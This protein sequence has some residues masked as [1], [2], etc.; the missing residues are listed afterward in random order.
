ML[1]LHSLLGD[2][3]VLQRDR[4]IVISGGASP[5]T[6]VTARF[7]DECLTATA[8][9]QGNWF[10]VF[11]AR[12]A[13]GPYAFSA[14]GEGQKLMREDWMIGEAWL[15]SGQSNMEWTL[16]MTPGSEADSAAADAPLV[17]CFTVPRMPTDEPAWNV[18]GKWEVA[19]PKTAGN[20][21][22]VAWF[23][24]RSLS[25]QLGCAVGIIV[26]AFGGTRIAS[27]LPRATLLA[28]RE[29]A[30]LISA[31]E[32]FETEGLQPHI[33][34]G[35]SAEAVGWEFGEL[36]D[37][38]WERL[39]V[40]GFWQDQGWA[41]NGAVWYRREVEIP[42][43]WRNQDLVL[44]FGACDDFDE[45]F[46]NGVRVGGM[47]PGLSGAYATPRDYP[48]AAALTAGCRLVIAVRIFDEWGFGGIVRAATLRLANA[49]DNPLPL[50]GEWKARVETAY[51][52]RASTRP[53]P[54]AV[55]YN[56]MIHPLRQ[57]AVRG[58]LWYQGE[59]DVERSGLYRMLLGDLIAAW[60]ADWN[61]PQKPF[62]IVQ[63]ANYKVPEAEPGESDWAEL[64]DAQLHTARTI[65]HTGLVVI[66][67]TGEADNVHPR[68]KR[69]VGERLARWALN[70]VY[71]QKVEPPGSPYPVGHE[72]RE[73]AVF[74]RFLQVGEG[75]RSRDGQPLRAFQISDPARRWTWAM[76]D[77]VAP[78]TIR[79]RSPAVAEP[80]AV[81]HGWQDNP[82]CNLENSAGLPATPFRTDEGKQ[83]SV[84]SGRP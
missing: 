79:I 84:L 5:G 71:G 36:D 59:S 80:M 35:R 10:A 62:G 45:T 55:L 11:S 25:E 41:L 58:F 66:I 76:A 23:F 67:D 83:H 39:Q 14:E 73:G 52:L 22:A 69:P 34:T 43:G 28:R 13:G 54:A 21:S 56:G 42:S 44:H 61:D 70:D 38:N 50:E 12:G 1:R 29:Y 27:W 40:P 7:V 20:F 3:A 8:D 18:E 51:P 32:L 65:P 77:I 19:S 74:V 48:V 53:I 47:G 24:A 81:R 9:A 57:A 64:R 72:I 60:R 17:R 68:L 31:D 46:V 26:P 4:D 16:A 37:E 82:P 63:L 6:A 78:D 75:L 33:D 49:L 15:C 2:H 30:R